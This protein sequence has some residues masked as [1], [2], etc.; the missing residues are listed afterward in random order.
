MTTNTGIPDKN[1]GDTFTAAEFNLMNNAINNFSGGA[2]PFPPMP[3]PLTNE[4]H[5]NASVRELP[6]NGTAIN[7]IEVPSSF[8]ASRD[9]QGYL[10]NSAVWSVLPTD[11]NAACDGFLGM[12]SCWYDNIND[13]LWV[14]GYDTSPATIYTAYITLETGVVTNVGSAVLTAAVVG[15]AA[16][17]RVGVSRSSVDSGNFT[18]TTSSQTFVISDSDGSLVSFTSSVT[19]GKTGYITADGTASFGSLYVGSSGGTGG[20]V[21]AN[22]NGNLMRIPTPLGL[23]GTLSSAA[24]SIYFLPWG[25]KIKVISS[26]AN[27]YLKATFDRAEFDQWV[28]DLLKYGGVE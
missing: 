18:L 15:Y 13:R 10:N 24:R 1:T 8:S 25:D 14:F 2:Y 12:Y 7:N 20:F 23:I 26:N 17:M 9:F 28:Q 16:E 22:K 27:S 4:G 5:I 6:H 19:N 11:I 3:T 21:D